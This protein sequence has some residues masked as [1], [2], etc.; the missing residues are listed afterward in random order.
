MIVTLA[1]QIIFRGIAEIVLGSGG[2]ISVTNTDGFRMIG[3]KVGEVPYILFL[4][5]ILAVIFAVI[6]GKKYFRTQGIRYRYQPSDRIL[7]RNPCTEDRMIIYTVMGTISD[8]ARC[9]WYPLPTAPI[10]QQVT[11]SRWTPSQWRYSAVSLLQA[12]REILPA[13]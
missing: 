12:V 10:P 11:A 8:C 1:T 3:G 5:L 6:L 13:A 9:F 2:S 7:F 4:V